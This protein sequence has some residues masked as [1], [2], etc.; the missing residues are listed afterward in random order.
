MG[1]AALGRPGEE[2]SLSAVPIQKFAEL[3]SAG[4][5]RAAVPTR[6]RCLLKSRAPFPNTA[7]KIGIISR[8]PRRGIDVSLLF[9]LRE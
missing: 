8:G 2:G 1:T 4:Q 3:R 9:E 6:L 7:R 5:P